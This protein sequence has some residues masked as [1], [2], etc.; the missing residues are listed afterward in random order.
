MLARGTTTWIRQI[1][2]IFYAQMPLIRPR[3][4]FSLFFGL[5]CGA[6]GERVEARSSRSEGQTR[7]FSMEVTHAKGTLYPALQLSSFRV[8]GTAVFEMLLLVT[9]STERAWRSREIAS[10]CALARASTSTA[11]VL[12]LRRILS[13]LECLKR[14][15]RWDAGRKKFA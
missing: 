9:P 15:R 3:Y 4:F 6:V 2:L 5:F 14:V 8:R 11:V 13:F 7:E 12:F 1:P 10:S